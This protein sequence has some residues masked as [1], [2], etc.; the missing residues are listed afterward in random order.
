MTPERFQQIDKL[1]DLALEREPSERG[2]F[3]DEACNGDEALRTKLESLLRSH[4]QA[5]GF[6]AEPPS[7]LANEILAARERERAADER[8]DWPEGASKILGR[9][10]VTE[11]LG[12][13]GMGV[14]YA[15][16]DPELDR[17]IAI[18]LMLP[19][20]R[21]SHPNVIAVHDVGTFGEQVFIAMEYV[22]GST[23][24]EWLSAKKRPWR[25][26]VSN[27]AQAGRGLAAAHAAS[28][29]HRDFKPDNVLVGNDGRVR[30]LDFG[31]RVRRKPPMALVRRQPVMDFRR[32]LECSA[33]P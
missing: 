12:G 27:F 11:K 21:L 4:Q 17:K 29:I 13:G 6:L 24:A 10:V 33:L 3:L 2:R 23:L 8:K 26:V 14:V 25:E 22:D 32:R 20:A 31:L 19:P 30:V 7:D 18:K 1:L 16:H 9:Y 15:A 28:I 5:P